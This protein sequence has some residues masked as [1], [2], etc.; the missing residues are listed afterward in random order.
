MRILLD[1]CI[2][3][4]LRRCFHSHECQTCRYAGLKGLSNGQPIAAA[5]Q[6]GFEVLITVDRNMPHQQRL[7]GREICL[8][9]LQART[10]DFDD[11]LPLIPELLTSLEI[12]KPGQVIRIGTV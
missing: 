12:L 6:A 2:D 4:G 1:E 7:L 8:I 3:E 11:L 10:T 5:E 9:I